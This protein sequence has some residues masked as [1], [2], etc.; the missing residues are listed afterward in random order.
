MN[1]NELFN[2]EWI[3]KFNGNRYTVEQIQ[4]V[5]SDVVAKRNRINEIEKIIGKEI[6]GPL[7]LQHIAENV[8]PS[9]IVNNYPGR[10]QRDLERMESKLASFL[11]PDE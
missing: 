11:N 3:S 6:Y 2:S 8:S 5:M 4:A 10:F 7:N 9:E 1:I